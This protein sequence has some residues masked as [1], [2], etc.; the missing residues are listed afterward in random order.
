[1]R[2]LETGKSSHKCAARGS[3]NGLRLFARKSTDK[4]RILGRPGRAGHRA[5]LHRRHQYSTLGSKERAKSSNTQ[6][7]K[8]AIS[9]FPAAIHPLAHVAGVGVALG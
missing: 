4:C 5:G 2:V 9:I 8:T 3:Q 6:Y 1:M 7:M